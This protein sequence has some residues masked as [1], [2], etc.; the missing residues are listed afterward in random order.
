MIKLYNVS[1]SFFGEKKALD[2][3]N[4][5]VKPGEFL[6]ITGES[7]AGKSTLLR[8]IYADLYPTR[9]VVMVDGQNVSNMDSKSIPFLRRRI[10]VV[11]QDFKLLE[12]KS[13]YDNLKMALEF[14]YMDPKAMQERIH[15]LLKQLGIFVK[16]DT[17]VKKLS[18]GEKQ[19]VAI[20][21]AL[22]NEPRVILAD[23][24]TG[25]LDHDNADSIMKLLLENRDKGATVI[26]ATHDDRLMQE[27]PA[28]T[29]ALKYGK[30]KEDTGAEESEEKEAEA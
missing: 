5:K 30:V 9:G 26:V 24:P 28:R 3:V 17:T 16:R 29:I 11:F 12:E 20:A 22:I 8:L 7:G 1:V 23:E 2:G 6:Y 18:G 14:F 4:I 13:V 15:P 27:Y 19:R 25:N 21:R 10:G